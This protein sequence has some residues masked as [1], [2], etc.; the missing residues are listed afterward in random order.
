MA[1]DAFIA[2]AWDEHAADPQGVAARLGDTG[3][4]LVSQESQVAPL[5]TLAHHVCGEHLGR[6]REGLDLLQR[7]A[8]LPAAAASGTAAEAL[9]RCQASLALCAGDADA[10]P[11]LTLS[12]RIRVGAM[13]AA[14]LGLHDAPRALELLRQASAE[15]ESSALPDADPAHRALAANGNNLACTL[16]E[17][18]APR[19]PEEVA[20]MIL[21]A[22]TARRHWALAGTW[23]ETERADYRLAMSWL[24]AG[25]A[26]RARVHADDCLALVQAHGAPP[27]EA[28]FAW[29]AQALVARAASDTIVHEDALEHMRQALAALDEA[30]RIWCQP[31]LDK[32]AG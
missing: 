3:L 20:L 2:Q 22:Q 31:S 10:R 25:D 1:F 18:T 6:W 7:L 30:D 9:R 24:A 17:K 12:D 21:A 14:S 19:S 15:A 11:A 23:L 13:A 5:A 28:F 8:A 27:L 16:E 26:A 29:E 32:A 4:A